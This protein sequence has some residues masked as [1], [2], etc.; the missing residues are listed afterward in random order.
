MKIHFYPGMGAD[1]RIWGDIDN[2]YPEAEFHNWIKP[3]DLKMSFSD[4]ALKLIELHG[5]KIGDYVIGVSMGAL[6]AAEI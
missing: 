6:L 2:M 3:Y 4:Y 5:I 1:K